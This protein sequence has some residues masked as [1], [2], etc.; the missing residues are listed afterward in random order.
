MFA[1]WTMEV[2]WLLHGD[3]LS[4]LRRALQPPLT[5]F[6]TR[7]RVPLRE[8]VTGVYRALC[9]ENNPER[10]S[11]G[12]GQF[13]AY[14]LVQRICLLF[15]FVDIDSTGIIDWVHFTDFCVFMR[16][17]DTGIQRLEDGDGA[18]VSGG[19]GDQENDITRFTEK[20]GYVDRSSHCH[21]VR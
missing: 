5:V 13:Q 12:M 14:Q 7:V 15:D 3:T 4:R 21:E 18:R 1:A 8:F 20:L 19:E 11:S 10:G 2:I 6:T 9:L 16:G 17:G